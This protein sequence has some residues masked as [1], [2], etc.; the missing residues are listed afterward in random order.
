MCRSVSKKEPPSGPG[1]QMHFKV[2][3]Y[4][5]SR[6]KY[7]MKI[8][9]VQPNRECCSLVIYSRQSANCATFLCYFPS[10]LAPLFVPA[11]NG[12]R[13]VGSSWLNRPKWLGQVGC[14]GGLE[15]MLQGCYRCVTGVLKGCFRV[16]AGVLQGVP[17]GYY[18]FVTGLSHIFS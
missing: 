11:L 7:P 2:L 18:S 5:Y 13:Q 9:L 4:K 15:V 1:E 17:E 8:I 3:R 12:K 14:Y 6:R 16:V 10:R